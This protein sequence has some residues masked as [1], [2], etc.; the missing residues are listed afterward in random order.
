MA[1]PAQQMQQGVARMPGLA[2]SAVGRVSYEAAGIWRDARALSRGQAAA[3]ED[4]PGTLST[5]QVYLAWY[6]GLATMAL[7]RLIEWRLAAMVAAVHTIERHAHRRR[8]TEYL[9]GVDAGGL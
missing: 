2:G 7:L 3:E 9:E 8:V 4:R 1:L 5:N 6:G